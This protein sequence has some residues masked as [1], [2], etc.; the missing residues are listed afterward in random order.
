MTPT[1]TLERPDKPFR[2]DFQKDVIQLTAYVCKAA[3][4]FG[5]NKYPKPCFFWSKFFSHCD[6]KQNSIVNCTKGPFLQ[7]ELKSHQILGGKKVR[8]CLFL[9]IMSSCRLPELRSS[10]KVDWQSST[11]E[12]SKP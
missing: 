11:R 10:T 1:P 6:N 5:P 8:S 2:L 9:K 3:L 7:T 4:K 12:M